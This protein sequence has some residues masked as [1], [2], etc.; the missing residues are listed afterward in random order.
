M[1]STDKKDP[2][3]KA[4]QLTLTDED[5]TSDRS[6]GRRGMLKSV[7]GSIL[8]GTVVSVVGVSAK[9]EEPAELAT[10][11]DPN[12]AAGRGRTG[13][14]DSDS[15]SNA[16]GAGHGRRGGGGGGGRRGGGVSDSDS[17][18]NADAAGRG[19]TG[20]SDSDSGSNADRAGHGRR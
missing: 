14:T 3:D 8:A 2:Q 19:R 6:M 12:D 16:D 7:G 4:G 10:D 5:I 9:A 1:S 13:R 15:G 17:G 20:R 18:P 11:S